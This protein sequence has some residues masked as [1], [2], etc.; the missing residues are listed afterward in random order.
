MPIVLVRR[1]LSLAVLASTLASSAALAT[2][3]TKSFTGTLTCFSACTPASAATAY[4]EGVAFTGTYSYDDSVVPTSGDPTTFRDYAAHVAI[5]LDIGSGLYTVSATEWSLE[6]QRQHSNPNITLQ[7]EVFFL[8]GGA[9][10]LGGTGTFTPFITTSAPS[11]IHFVDFTSTVV[12]PD[13]LIANWPQTVA[14]WS[15]GFAGI[16]FFIMDASSNLV[17]FRGAFATLVDAGIATTTLATT[18][19]PD[20]VLGAGS[21]LDGATVSGRVNPLVGATVDFQLFG[22]N[23]PTCAGAPV[24]QTLGVPY[25]VAGG[26]VA[27]GS[28]TPALAGS[29][30]WI[31]S[32][33]GDAN[34]A[35]V[36]G[37]C[38][39][40][41][42]SAVVQRAAPAIVSTASLSGATITDT[43]TVSGRVNGLASTLDFRLYGPGDPTCAGA[44]VFV[45]AGATYPIAGGPLSSAAF[46]APSPGTYR[47]VASYSGDANNLPVAAP[48]G[49]AGESVEVGVA[50]VP[51][52][53]RWALFALAATLAGMG[54][55]IGRARSRLR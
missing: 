31:A 30:R 50:T 40:P 27:S 47:W 42:E 46:V 48:C 18:A 44:P 15:T 23:D 4:L 51:T 34:N 19:S 21:L 22:P 35:P 33:S 41:G 17:E 36:A 39:D 45:S 37:A 9:P 6:I 38:G 49:A 20:I 8:N 32:Y 10:T 5:T 28:F 53:S 29:Y 2:I 55:A 16:E 3:L 14:A 11:L 25:P 26:A 52:L 24:F 12:L 54:L 13:T 1:S 43:A 7:D